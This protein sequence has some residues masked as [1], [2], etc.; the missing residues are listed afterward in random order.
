LLQ[1][2][3]FG[4]FHSSPPWTM[5]PVGLFSTFLISGWCTDYGLSLGFS[6]L[7]CGKAWFRR[8]KT[9]AWMWSRPTSSGTGTNQLKE[10][11]AL[12]SHLLLPS[13]LLP[14]P[15]VAQRELLW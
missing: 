15:Q 9:E 3:F 2:P 4:E 12:H 5:W 11:Y 10:M 6:L 1:Q 14:T 13:P 7:R 8:R